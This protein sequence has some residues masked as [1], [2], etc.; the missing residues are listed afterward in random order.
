MKM[1]DLEGRSL[2]TAEGLSTRERNVFA[3]A[4]VAKGGVQCG[5]CT[6]GIVMKAKAMLDKNPSP[7]RD[8][9][10]GWLSGNICRC[11]GYKKVIDSIECAAVAFREGKPVGMPQG[12][13]R[14]GTRHAKYTGR[15][16]VLGDRVFVGD[17]K[18]PGMIFGAL[19][20]S[21]HPRAKVLRIDVSAAQAVPGVLRVL[22]AQDVPGKRQMGSITMDWP[23]L[24]AE[25][26]TTC[27]VGDVLA[28]VAAETEV[29]AR[30]AAAK[31]KVE[32]EVL[33]P[34]TDLFEALQ[35]GSDQVQPT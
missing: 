20:F 10:A 5:F 31:V 9:I 32:Y 6:P 4:F 30:E 7:T 23:A 34:V 2:T 35:P 3:D 25:G 33:R 22:T 11:T 28:T 1:K 24:V 29:I 21:D 16:A 12:T 27:F 18:E 26:E 13:G 14:V 15:E 19:R 8:E 17:M